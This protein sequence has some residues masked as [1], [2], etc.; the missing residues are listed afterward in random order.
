[1]VRSAVVAVCVLALSARCAVRESRPATGETPPPAEALDAQ[2]AGTTEAPLTVPA[3]RACEPG[4]ERYSANSF[5]W[6]QV[7]GED[8]AWLPVKALLCG[9]DAAFRRGTAELAPG[10]MRW[11]DVAVQIII[12]NRE[13]LEV[14]GFHAHRRGQR[15]KEEA[16]ARRRAEVVRE[17]M[18]SRGATPSLVLVATKQRVPEPDAVTEKQREFEVGV[19]VSSPAPSGA[20][21]GVGGGG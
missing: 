7:C 9:S 5:C 10:E 2:P 4:E 21:A 12:H 8:G 17:L 3:S 20:D 14:T 13:P 1:M 11:V 18:I 15:P 19:T 6:P 16:L